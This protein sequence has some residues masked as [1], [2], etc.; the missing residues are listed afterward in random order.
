[1]PKNDVKWS[2]WREMYVS[3]D[4][5]IRRPIRRLNLTF[6]NYWGRNCNKISFFDITR[7]PVNVMLPWFIILIN[8]YKI[9]SLNIVLVFRD[10][11]FEDFQR[12]LYSSPQFS[13]LEVTKW[14]D[15]KKLD[16]ILTFRFKHNQRTASKCWVRCGDRIKQPHG[17]CGSVLMYTQTPSIVG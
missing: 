12:C 1:M 2:L 10:Y 3:V 16:C 14:T 6:D 4:P 15:I 7:I 5:R 13:Y 9:I 17:A 8:N 11:Y